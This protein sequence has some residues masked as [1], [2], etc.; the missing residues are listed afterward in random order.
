MLEKAQSIRGQ[1]VMERQLPMD[2]Y[3]G[4]EISRLDSGQSTLE[5]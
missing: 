4:N 3:K 2:F 1:V 5:Q